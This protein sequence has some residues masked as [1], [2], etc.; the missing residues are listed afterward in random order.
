[1]R[2]GYLYL[3]FLHLKAKGIPVDYATNANEGFTNQGKKKR[4]AST[5]TWYGYDVPNSIE[6]YQPM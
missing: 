3:S 1:M 4:K 6:A 2:V 5:S